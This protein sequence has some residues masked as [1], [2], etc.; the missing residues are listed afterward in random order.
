MG[1]VAAGYPILAQEN[2][3]E[4]YQIDANLFFPRADYLLRVKGMSMRDCGILDGDLLAVHTTPTATNGQVVVARL[5]DEVTVKRF[6][7]RGNIVYLL[8]ENP[9]FSPIQVNLKEQALHIEG[10]AVGI[11]RSNTPL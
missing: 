8:P 2:I 11:I 3:E 1:Q 10:V 9:D 7:R 4:H 6:Q 5:D